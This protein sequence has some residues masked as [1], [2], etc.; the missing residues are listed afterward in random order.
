MNFGCC[1]FYY[2]INV[3]A[4]NYVVINC[5]IELIRFIFYNSEFAICHVVRHGNVSGRRIQVG[6]HCWISHSIGILNGIHVAVVYNVTN[7]KLTNVTTY[8][9]ANFKF[10]TNS[11]SDQGISHPLVHGGG[12]GRLHG[13]QKT[14]L[15]S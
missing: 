8:T 14:T 6:L 13:T 7:R 11:Q 10:L 5:L 1:F 3:S 15:P 12:G 2:F 9:P 4:R